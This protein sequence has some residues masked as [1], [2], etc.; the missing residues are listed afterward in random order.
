[1]LLSIAPIVLRQKSVLNSSLVEPP[2]RRNLRWAHAE[3]LKQTT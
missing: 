2:G 1:M 3:A